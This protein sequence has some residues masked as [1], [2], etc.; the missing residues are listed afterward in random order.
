MTLGII[1]TRVP[2]VQGVLEPSETAALA[3]PRVS[4][5]VRI[6]RKNNYQTP[7]GLV[8]RGLVCPSGSRFGETKYYLSYFEGQL[9]V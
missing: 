1:A 7:K 6:S 2:R 3:K 4:E 8:L 9:G 5:V